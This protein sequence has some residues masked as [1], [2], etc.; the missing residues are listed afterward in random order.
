MAPQI[1]FGDNVRIRNTSA[2]VAVGLSVRTDTSG[3]WSVPSGPSESSLRTVGA[4]AQPAV[5]AFGATGRRI[6]EGQDANSAAS[7]R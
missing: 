2:T 3:Q 6:E 1:A 7:P 5:A 4:A